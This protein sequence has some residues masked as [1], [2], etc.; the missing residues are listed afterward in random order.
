MTKC[1]S[2]VLFLAVAGACKT[3][4]AEPAPPPKAEAAAKLAGVWPKDF[5]CDSIVSP[6]ALAAVL[7]GESKQ[8]D[9][10][11]SVPK[12]VPMPCKYEVTH[13]S[14][15]E[16][17]QFDF[18]CRDNMKTTADALF[19][20]YRKQNLEMIADWN[21]KSDA[22]VFKPNDAGTEYNRPGNP[23]EVDVGA[24]GLDHHGQALIFI[25][26]DAP[27][28]VRVAGKDSARRLVLA[29]LLAK[30]LTFQNAP[31]TPRPS[32]PK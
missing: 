23:V 25:D 21:T 15:L 11:G 31:M 32:I 28:Y 16:L 3:E 20:Q 4:H 29:K 5:K 6:E 18:D 13:D 19:E 14:T 24:K 30:N 1:S 22:G 2:L 26:D 12:G 17:W 10:P 9:N 27:C 7:G 8:T